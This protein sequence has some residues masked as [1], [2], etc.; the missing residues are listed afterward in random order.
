[1]TVE[2]TIYKTCEGDDTPFLTRSTLTQDGE[3]KKL[4]N[5][6]KRDRKF[7]QERFL[8][9]L[10]AHVIMDDYSRAAISKERAIFLMHINCA[11]SR[12]TTLL[13]MEKSGADARHSEH[14]AEIGMTE[15]L[16]HILEGGN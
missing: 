3:I 8:R 2:T 15:E 6:M 1:M 9:D 5:A 14:L 16:L 13:I 7:Q 12:A 4:Q 10:P 11:R